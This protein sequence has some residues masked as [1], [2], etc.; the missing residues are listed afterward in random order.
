MPS[1]VSFTHT[2]THTERKHHQIKTKLNSTENLT[3][4]I[5]SATGLYCSL[6]TLVKLSIVIKSKTL[7]VNRCFSP[8]TGRLGQSPLYPP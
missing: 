7:T 5:S 4:T 6:I 3:Q 8:F 1:Y 2:R